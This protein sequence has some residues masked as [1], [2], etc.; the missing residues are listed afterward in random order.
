MGRARRIT[1]LILVIA[2]AT[3]VGTTGCGGSDAATGSTVD[4]SGEEAAATFTGAAAHKYATFGKEASSGER[5]AASA[6]LEQNY[7]ARAA[8]EWAKQCAS[9][10]PK[11]VKKVEQ[12]DA[13]VGG[14]KGCVAAIKLEAE[15]LPASAAARANTLT[16][17]I[18]ALR[19][20][21]DQA[22][23]LYHGTHQKDFAIAMEKV[24]GQWKVGALAAT[25]LS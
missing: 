1:A 21:G 4:K 5:E 14:A 18:D 20:E 13:L 11:A 8:A 10:S 23:A 16:G 24:K 22:Y 25:E 17:P 2:T 6:V 12:E 3:V 7:R 15:P 9:L 19:T